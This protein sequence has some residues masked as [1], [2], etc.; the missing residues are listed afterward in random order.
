VFS[1]KFLFLSRCATGHRTI[2]SSAEKSVGH[3]LFWQVYDLIFQLAKYKIHNLR[4]C[5]SVCSRSFSI[6]FDKFMSTFMKRWKLRALR[7]RWGYKPVAATLPCTCMQLLFC[8]FVQMPLPKQL[9]PRSPPP[10][11]MLIR[12]S[13]NCPRLRRVSDSMLWVRWEYIVFSNFLPDYHRW[14]RTKQSDL[15]IANNS[16]RCSRPARRTETGRPI[17]CC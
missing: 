14:Q 1:I 15:H 2:G 3:I 11:V 9:W 8:R 12:E 7:Q 4:S 10:K 5:K 17:D 16:W 13:S 6:V